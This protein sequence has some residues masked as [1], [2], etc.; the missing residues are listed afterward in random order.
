MIQLFLVL[1]YFFMST[2][3]NTNSI[4]VNNE[5]ILYL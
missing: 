4:V 2:F 5:H 3:S 1:N